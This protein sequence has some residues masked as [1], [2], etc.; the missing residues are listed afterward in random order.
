MQCWS[1]IFHPTGLFIGNRVVDKRL[2]RKNQRLK[3]HESDD[4][5]TSLPRTL[6][7]DIRFTLTASG[8]WFVVV[9]A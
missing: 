4:S 7:S 6:L 5:R 9:G 1:L 8:C 2:Q 3:T